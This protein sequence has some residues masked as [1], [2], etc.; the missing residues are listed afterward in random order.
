MDWVN[1][2]D[3]AEARRQ[4]VATKLVELDLRYGSGSSGYGSRGSGS[5]D[6]A[7]RDALLKQINARLPED[8]KIAPQL[9]GADLETLEKF[10][11]AQQELAAFYQQN[12]MPYTPDQAEEDVI[13][14]HREVVKSGGKLDVSEIYA[15]LGIDE[16]MAGEEAFGGKTYEDLARSLAEGKEN[17]GIAFQMREPIKPVTLGEQGELRQLYIEQLKPTLETEMAQINA[18]KAQGN[19]SEGDEARAIE[20]NR[21]LD[22]LDNEAKDYALAARI[23]GP[24]AAIKILET[25]PRMKAYSY[26]INKN[27]NFTDDVNGNALFKR[28]IKSG[29]LSEGD[30]YFSNGVPGIVTADIIQKALKE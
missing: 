21:A 27:L 12:D 11:K 15:L 26:L 24:E 29:L 30:T 2:N 8:S 23:V 9:V 13:S 25:N 3:E 16:D 19:P 6:T 22:A 4:E 14:F 20:L 28:A 17:V 18:R 1:A 5:S 10:D 7:T